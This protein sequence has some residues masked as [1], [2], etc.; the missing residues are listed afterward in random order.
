M[1]GN[2]QKHYDHLYSSCRYSS[3]LTHGRKINPSIISDPAQSLGIHLKY[4]L[5]AINFL[6]AGNVQ[7]QEYHTCIH[8]AGTSPAR[9]MAGRW[10]P[11]VVPLR[12]SHSAST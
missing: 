6:M 2:E 10:P 3:C 8:L 4:F 11:V 12:H 9:P 1:A 5:P 7:K